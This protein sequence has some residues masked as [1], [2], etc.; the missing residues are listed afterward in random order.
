VTGRPQRGELWAADL[1]SPDPEHAQG[2]LRSVLVL[3]TNALNNAGH[4][5]TLVVP[6]GAAGQPMASGDNFPLRLRVPRG[7][8]MTHDAELLVDQLRA[9]DSTRLLQRQHILPPMLVARVEQA[10]LLVTGP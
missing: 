7:G 8:V 2:R 1:D 6:C 5:T 9:V 3:Q 10:L 4:P